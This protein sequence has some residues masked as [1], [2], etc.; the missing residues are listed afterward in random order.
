[1]NLSVEPVSETRKKIL[2]NVPGET[3]A[4]EEAL[5]LKN[6]VKQARI[7]GFRPGKV[8]LD[9]VKQRFK[10]EIGKELNRK[11]FSKAYEM[12]VNDDGLKVYSVIETSLD[13]DDTLT[14]ALNEVSFTVDVT[15]DFELP[16]YTQCELKVAKLE[17]TGEEVE[18]AK[19]QIL[20]ER[21]RY[22]V[23]DGAAVKGNFV[24][25]SYE[26]K[27][28]EQNVADMLPDYPKYGKQPSSWEEA[29]VENADPAIA[30]IAAA[31]VGKQ[32][33]DSFTV[34]AQFPDDFKPAEL[35]GKTVDYQVEVLEVRN[36]ILPVIDAAFLENFG[37]DT[38]EVWTQNIQ[39]YLDRDKEAKIFA[40][41]CEQM[42]EFLKAQI[43]FP[44]PLS[45]IDQGRD[46]LL[47]SYMHDA[48][49]KGATQEQ[50]EANKESLIE[51]AGKAA[52][53]RVKVAFIFD[54]I[55]QK[56]GIK[57]EDNDISQA[58]LNFCVQ[59]GVNPEKYVKELKKNPE[60][61]RNL[62]LHV[63]HNKVLEFIVKSAKV[64]EV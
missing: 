45:A 39:K 60:D 27:L 44:L 14:S 32:K 6:F 49:Q 59:R 4:E 55:A 8:P 31:A 41:K 62:Q 63:L 13:P 1:M 58:I 12:V 16:D 22:E 7:P 54:K 28:G 19:K 40:Q 15:P 3:I 47:R 50:F 30:A 23:T 51:S 53:D 17:T 61:L 34:Q 35:Q 36:K 43:D 48:M 52:E 2:V 46:R 64:V 56:E 25:L 24:K 57:L 38:E 18:A 10:K 20:E 42:T 9:M 26:G 37:A 11:I 29:G 5:L 33:G 21:A